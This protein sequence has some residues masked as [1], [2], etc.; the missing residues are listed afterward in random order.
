MLKTLIK[1]KI[2]PQYLNF[3]IW[4]FIQYNFEIAKISI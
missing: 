1:C 2:T 4:W 3:K